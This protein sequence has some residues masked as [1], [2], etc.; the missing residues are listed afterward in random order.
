MGTPVPF[1]VT[2]IDRETGTPVVSR[3]QALPIVQARFLKSVKAGDIVSGTVTGVIPENKIV[4]VEVQGYSCMIPPNE[5]DLNS[6][7]DLREVVMIGSE[8]EAKVMDIIPIKDIH[9]EDSDHD[10]EFRIRLSRR[11]LQQQARVMKWND[12]EQYHRVNDHVLAKVVAKAPG[13]NSYLIELASSGIVIVGNLQYPLSEQFRYGLPLGL[14]VQA[15]IANLDKAKMV[16]KARI[17]RID[18]SLQSAFT[19]GF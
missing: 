15:Q 6:V 4:F 12:I 19:S 8:V 7:S 5:W 18:P 11:Q 3:I 16:G 14:K 9:G 2:D 17:Y 13:P 1:I 10:F